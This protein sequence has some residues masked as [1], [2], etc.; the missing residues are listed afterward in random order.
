VELA[1]T[2]QIGCA[3]RVPDRLPVLVTDVLVGVC[4]E[5]LRRLWPLLDESYRLALVPKPVSAAG[6]GEYWELGVSTTTEAEAAVGQ[7]A[8]VVLREAL[9]FAAKYASVE[10]LLD[11]FGYD[12]EGG[13]VDQR[14]VALLAAAG[15]FAEARGALSRYRPL[16]GSRDGDREARRF[17]H[18]I[19]RYI[20]SGGDQSLVPSAPPP[21]SYASSPREPVSELW[22]QARA[23]QQAVDAVRRLRTGTDRA[24]LRAALERELT[25]RGLTESPLWYEQTLDHLHMSR[26]ES[27]ELVAKGVKAVGQLGLKAVRGLRERRLL[28]DLSVP[29]WL[30]C[31]D[32]AAYPVPRS[33]Q[34][35]WTEVQ[36]DDAANA[37][38][39]RAYAA[40]PRLSGPVA[41]VT[42]WLEWDEH[43]GER[44]VVSLGEQ[45]VGTLDSV[46][47]EAYRAA[48]TAAATRDE[49]P[50]APAR[51]TPRPASNGYLLELQL[52]D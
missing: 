49:L 17:V 31:P 36:L 3:S 2:A 47:T 15:R 20:D 12:K 42:A 10:Q 37:W 52:P 30:E 9:P 27:A 50:Y 23:R 1:A 28:P 29:E 35:G 16:T 5:P 41:T 34:A 48:T 44:L 22:R 11:E 46:A 13:W 24:E 14:A 4:Y 25:Q 7:L 40:I 8:E 26:A 6:D 51:L 45:R 19:G 32:R 33:Q 21:S 43:P 18:Q 39:D 38:L